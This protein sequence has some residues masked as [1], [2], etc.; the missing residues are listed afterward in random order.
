MSYLSS[1]EAVAIIPAAGRATRLGRIP[2]SKEL[3]P[4]QIAAAGSYA[5]A[6]GTP[7][8]IENLLSRLTDNGINKAFVITAPE[9]SDLIDF[10][11]QRKKGWPEITLRTKAA[12]PSVPHT[13]RESLDLAG[14]STVLLVFPD[15]LFHPENALARLLDHDAKS[16]REATLALVPSDRGDKVDMV[17]IQEDGTVTGIVAKPGPGNAGWTW[18]AAAWKPAISRR[19]MELTAGKPCPSAGEMHVSDVFTSA[20]KRGMSIGSICF[21]AGK[22]LDIGTP[23]DLATLWGAGFPAT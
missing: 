14:N 12:S 17:D 1:G 22:A 10:L 15:I 5:P 11:Q 2:C 8:A 18:I 23:E 7:V 20:I 16:G 9:K 4:L 6:P 13:L 21:P 3:I 19:L